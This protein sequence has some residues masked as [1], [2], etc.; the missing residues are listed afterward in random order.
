MKYEYDL[1]K[2]KRVPAKTHSYLNESAGLVVVALMD[3]NE[4]VISEIA[5][6]TQPDTR[7][8]C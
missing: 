6:A 8:I 4:T 1:K 5:K 2:G 7:K 3:W